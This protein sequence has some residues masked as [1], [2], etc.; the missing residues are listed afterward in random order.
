MSLCTVAK[1]QV[2]LTA[3]RSSIG[4]SALSVL[5]D[6]FDSDSD[7]R[8]SA[9]NRAVFVRYAL[10]GLRFVYKEPDRTVRV[11]YCLHCLVFYSPVFL[12][13]RQGCISIRPYSQSIRRP[14]QANSRNL[15]RLWP[16]N[17]CPHTLHHCST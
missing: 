14:S 13:A 15:T 2:V 6:V 9:E 7:L 1:S 5:K 16:P 3:W 17:W 12:L 10:D 8:E 4:K 11:T